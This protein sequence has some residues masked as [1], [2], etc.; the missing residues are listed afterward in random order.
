MGIL[1]GLSIG[2]GS[3]FVAWLIG[4]VKNIR[5]LRLPGAFALL[6][7]VP[8]AYQWGLIVGHGRAYVATRAV[9]GDFMAA[10]DTAIQGGNDDGVLAEIQRLRIAATDESEKRAGQFFFGDMESATDRLGRRGETRSPR[11]SEL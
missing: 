5:A 4:E 2:A 8:L 9:T 10:L 6:L 7:L 3:L 11:A 1:I